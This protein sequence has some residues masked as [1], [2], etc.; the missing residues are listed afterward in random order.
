[1][2]DTQLDTTYAAMA[3]AITRLGPEK[4]QLFLATLALELLS[5]QDDLQHCLQIIAQAERLAKQ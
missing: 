3:E 4:G 2:T 5:Q 1:M